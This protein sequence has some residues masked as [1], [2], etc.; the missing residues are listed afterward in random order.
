MME[1]LKR[2]LPDL[3]RVGKGSL[4]LLC[5]GWAE[6]RESREGVGDVQPRPQSVATNVEVAVRMG[7]SG[8]LEALVWRSNLEDLLINWMWGV[9][10]RQ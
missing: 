5:G 4:R 9:K 3:T 1:A 2:E 7:K 8:P 10:E 6:G